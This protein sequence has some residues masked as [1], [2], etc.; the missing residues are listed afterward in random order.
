MDMDRGMAA[1]RRIERREPM[2]AAKADRLQRSLIRTFG[3]SVMKHGRRQ[4]LSQQQQFGDMA[5]LSPHAFGPA[6]RG[7]ANVTFDVVARVAARLGT[8]AAELLTDN[9]Q[10]EPSHTCYLTRTPALRDYIR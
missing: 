8:T 9:H 2:L 10:I 3:E 1:A 4:K 5:D 7:I 6:E